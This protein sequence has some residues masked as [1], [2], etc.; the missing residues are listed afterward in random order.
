MSDY[1]QPVGRFGR[2]CSVILCIVGTLLSYL[3][4]A[5][6]LLVVLKPDTKEHTIII[7][8]L[9]PL[10]FA[11]L[12]TATLWVSIRLLRGSISNNQTTVMPIWFIQAFGWFFLASSALFVW[13][14]KYV[15]A[16]ET[17]AMGLG[18]I[19]IGR[20]FHKKH[21][22]PNPALHPTPTRNDTGGPS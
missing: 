7:L 19:L 11:A 14:K 10:F 17:A 2:I 9:I 1:L 20:R 8:W 22:T 13:Q 3:F 6:M 5:V 16:W 4:A 21:Q 15:Q 18:M 12:G